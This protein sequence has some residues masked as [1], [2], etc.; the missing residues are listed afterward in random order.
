M[1]FKNLSQLLLSDQLSH[2]SELTRPEKRTLSTA[3]WFMVYCSDSSF[4]HGYEMAQKF[5][6]I[7][8]HS[9]AIAPSIYLRLVNT[10]S[11][12]VSVVSYGCSDNNKATRTFVVTLSYATITKSVNHFITIVFLKLM[13]GLN[14]Y[15]MD[16]V[17]KTGLF[18]KAPV[19]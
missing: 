3:A 13:L 9:S 12:F 8:G 11:G 15:V 10:I 17:I 7:Y 2:S 16:Q 6:R 4:V 1:H 19:L 14:V 18:H 5:I